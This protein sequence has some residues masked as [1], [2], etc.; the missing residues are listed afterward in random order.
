MR[1]SEESFLIF[2]DISD[3]LAFISV[4]DVQY[5]VGTNDWK[6]GSDPIVVSVGTEVEFKALPKPMGFGWPCGERHDRNFSDLS[7]RSRV[8]SH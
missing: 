5:R 8:R 3:W 1:S 4:G 6:D 7:S 2:K